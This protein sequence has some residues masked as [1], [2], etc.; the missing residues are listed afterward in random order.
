M[1]QN[2]KENDKKNS[3]SRGDVRLE[4]KGKR[5]KSLMC[6]FF[7]VIKRIIMQYGFNYCKFTCTMNASKIICCLTVKFTIEIFTLALFM[8]GK[9]IYPLKE[10]LKEQ[11]E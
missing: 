6:W 2:K 4:K 11:K 7:F 10:N 9:M 1:K 8:Y 3:E 5:R